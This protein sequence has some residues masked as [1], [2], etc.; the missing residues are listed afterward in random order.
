V[1]REMKTM[2]VFYKESFKEESFKQKRKKKEM[3]EMTK[4]M[5]TLY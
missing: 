1:S 5:M 2:L 3:M 4:R